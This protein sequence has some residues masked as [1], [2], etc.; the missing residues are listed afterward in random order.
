MDQRSGIEQYFAILFALFLLG[1]AL[2]AAGSCVTDD[3]QAKEANTGG[4]FLTVG[5]VPGQCGG[6]L[7]VSRRSEPKTLNP[8]IAGDLTSKEIISLLTADLIHI[9]RS[10][11][12]SESAVAKSWSVSDGGRRYTLHLRRGLRFSDGHP[13]D[14][15]DVV[16]TFRAYLD[17]RIHSPQRDLLIVAD[18][19]I[20]VEKIDTYTVAFLLA[21][22]YAA[23]ERLFDSIAILPQHL[24]EHAYDQGNLGSAWGLNTA[25][26]LIA[27]LGP[28][29]LKEYIPGDKIIL[30]RNRFYWKRDLQGNGLPYLDEIEFL[31]IGSSEAEV[32]RFEAGETQLIDRLNAQ[33]FDVLQ[34]DAS[35]HKFSLYDAGA[36][37]EYSFLLFNLNDLP[38]SGE[39]SLPEKQRWFRQIAFR[40]AISSAID[41]DAIVRLAYSGRADPLST[42]V[43]PG[44]K[45]WFDPAI[46]KGS[47]SLPRA[48]QLL[49]DAGFQW[50]EDRSLTDSLGK[51]VEFSLLQNAGRIQ[52]VQMAAIIQQD[53]KDIGIKVN[54]IPLDFGSLVDRIFTSFKYEAAIMVLADGDADPNSEMN[55]W[56]SNGTTH[57]WKLRSNTIPDQQQQE[58]DRLM[59][60]QMVMLDPSRRKQLFDRVQHLVWEY[61]PVVFLVSPSILAAASDRIGNFRPAV[62]SSY[63][64]WNADQLFI[65]GRQSAAAH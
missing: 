49:R 60:E 32:L 65:R 19:P 26:E 28:F 58:I 15:D 11:Q 59:R 20:S 2:P 23:A 18:K 33:D 48:R 10:T 5:G 54:L 57:L 12:Q 38:P 37:M 50:R 27:G 44:N 36:G 6:A 61:Q 3:R 56:L 64:L 17:D 25:P 53:L 8:L 55:V 16:F 13:V 4:D 41:R 51:P 14:A 45:L 21:K 39:P 52:Y 47:R 35:L 1:G 31:F 63:T 29:R 9:N 46:P 62:L 34:R 24:L 43:S 42:Q 40:E 7:V 22:P 30:Q